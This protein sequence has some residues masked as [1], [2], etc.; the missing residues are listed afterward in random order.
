MRLKERFSRIEEKAWKRE[1]VRNIIG[2]ILMIIFCLRL[3]RG[4]SIGDSIILL[5]F[6]GGLIMAPV[7]LLFMWI[8]ERLHEKEINFLKTWFLCRYLEEHGRARVLFVD[9]FY[10]QVI[11]KEERKLEMYV[12]EDGIGFFYVWSCDASNNEKKLGEGKYKSGYFFQHF[13]VVE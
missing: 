6:I 10:N 13:K 12:R 11:A 2:V 3:I 8:S 1:R 4:N 9:D 5:I 7:F